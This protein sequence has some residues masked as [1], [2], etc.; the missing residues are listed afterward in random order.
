MVPMATYQC[1]PPLLNFMITTS[2]CTN[3]QYG[4]KKL[5]G[6]IDKDIHTRMHCLCIG[7][8]LVV[9]SQTTKTGTTMLEGYKK[10]LRL[11]SIMSC[12]HSRV[13]F[14]LQLVPQ[15]VHIMPGLITTVNSEPLK[16]D[17]PCIQATMEI[18]FII[19]K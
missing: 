10:T 12:I 19:G 9:F 8:Q 15:V 11:K 13:F 18:H 14:W 3:I 5:E 4:A 2:L 16:C 17:H 6:Q 7:F 1:G